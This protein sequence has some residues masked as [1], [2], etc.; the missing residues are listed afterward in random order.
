MSRTIE[1]FLPHAAEAKILD[2]TQKTCVNLLI[3]FCS[4]C[5]ALVPIARP[6]YS[7]LSFYM[8]YVANVECWTALLSSSQLSTIAYMN[9]NRLGYGTA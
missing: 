8:I 7:Y 4:V 9:K 3:I 5:K 2:F 6:I 1:T